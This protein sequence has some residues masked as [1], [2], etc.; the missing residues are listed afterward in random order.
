ME[1]KLGQKVR[2]KI[3][4]MEG[5]AIGRTVWLNGCV[6]ISVQPQGLKDGLPLEPQWVDEPQL[7]VVED[8]VAPEDKPTGGPR[9]DSV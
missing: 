6:R 3:T 1:I 7:E 8:T 9:P 5:T 4:T 2:D